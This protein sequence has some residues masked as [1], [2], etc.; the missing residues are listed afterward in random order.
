MQTITGTV[1]GKKLGHP[2]F[3]FCLELALISTKLEEKT[4]LIKYQQMR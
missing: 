1:I 4:S 2:V 3:I